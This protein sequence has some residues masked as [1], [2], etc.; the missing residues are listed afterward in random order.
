M[1][2]KCEKCGKRFKV[3]GQYALMVLTGGTDCPICKKENSIV[4]IE[5]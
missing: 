2:V 3:T 4:I 1:N 5:G